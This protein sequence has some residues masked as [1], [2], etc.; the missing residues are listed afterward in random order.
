MCRA[1]DELGGVCANLVRYPDR[2][3]TAATYL[4][5]A[6]S[7]RARIHVCGRVLVSAS[8]P[9]PLARWVL[10]APAVRGRVLGGAVPRSRSLCCRLLG[11]PARTV[12]T[13]SALTRF[14]FV[15]SA[16]L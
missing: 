16:D 8:R 1:A 10:D 2:C 6:R 4:R 9:L 15:S 12:R 14:S 5:R 3:A 11:W 7:A 13:R